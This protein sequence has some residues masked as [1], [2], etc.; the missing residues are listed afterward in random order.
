MNNGVNNES[1]DTTA[2]SKTQLASEYGTS[3]RTFVSWLKNHD[4]QTGRRKLLTSKEVGMVYT[5]IGIPRENV[6]IR[7]LVR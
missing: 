5:R 1:L 4:I 3:V 2:K 6:P 7:R